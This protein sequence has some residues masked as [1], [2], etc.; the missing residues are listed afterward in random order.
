VRKRTRSTSANIATI[1]SILLQGYGSFQSEDLI[2]KRITK[3]GHIVCK[4]TGEC[5]LIDTRIIFV[6]P[7]TSL[8]S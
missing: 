3:H 8:K 5:P 6:A 4:A 1:D 7:F 2:S